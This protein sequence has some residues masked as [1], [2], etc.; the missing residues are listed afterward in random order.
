MEDAKKNLPQ[1]GLSFYESE[2]IQQ[3]PKPILI[4]KYLNEHIF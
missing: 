3:L 1:P 4:N 2:E